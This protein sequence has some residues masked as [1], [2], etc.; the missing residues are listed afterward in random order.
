MLLVCGGSAVEPSMISSPFF[1][2]HSMTVCNTTWP[3]DAADLNFNGHS[4][5]VLPV[6]SDSQDP[7]RASTPPFPCSFPPGRPPTRAGPRVHRRTVLFGVTA[8]PP[9]APAAPADPP[10][11]TQRLG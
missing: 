6:E 1:S 5:Q 8:R 3:L 10:A 4:F 9:A 11:Q 7:G 2:A